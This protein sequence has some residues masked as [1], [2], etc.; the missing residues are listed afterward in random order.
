LNEGPIVIAKLKPEATKHNPTISFRVG[1]DEYVHFDA[2][3]KAA[4]MT[5]SEFFREYFFKNKVYV[6]ARQA[7]SPE[8]RRAVLLLQKASINVEELLFIADRDRLA[9]SLT[10]ATYEKLIKQLAQLNKFMFSQTSE[11]K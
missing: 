7:P 5:K 9:G 11:V 10:D 1:E 6:K 2:Q 4:N 8:S 3:C